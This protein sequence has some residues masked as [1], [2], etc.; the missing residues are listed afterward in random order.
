MARHALGYLTAVDPLLMAPQYPVFSEGTRIGRDAD[1]CDI[2]IASDFVSR[3]HCMVAADNGHIVLFDGAGGH[4]ASSNGTFVNGEPVTHHVLSE[5]DTISC[6]RPSPPHFVYTRTPRSQER[7]FL[8]ALQ[9]NYLIGRLGE[10]D[11][12]LLEDPTVSSR[13]ATLRARGGALSIHDAGSANGLYVNGERVGSAAIHPQDIVRIGSTE[14]TFELEA[15][16]LRVT[17]RER[18]NQV[19]MRAVDL[20]R[21][22]RGFTL[23]HGIDLDI[24][25]GAFVGVLGPSGAG[26]STLLNALNGFVPADSGEVLLNG[27]SLYRAYD[28]FRN[29]IGYVP[30]DDIIH[31]ELTVERS[32]L[33]TAQLRLPRDYSRPALAEQV[34]SVIETLGLT[35]VRHNFVSNLSGGQRKR[36]SIGCELLTR[37]SLMF[38]DEPTSGLDPSTEEKLMLHFRRMSEQGQTVVLTTHILYNLQLLDKVILLSRGRLVYY[39]PTDG[40]CPFFSTPGRTIERPIEVF[41]ILEPE[42]ADSSLRDERAEFY[43]EKYQREREQIAGS[44]GHGTTGRPI[45]IESNKGASAGMRLKKAVGSFLDLRQLGILVRRSFDLK[46]SFPMR[47]AVPMV[48]PILLALLT[49]TISISD[50]GA[51]QDERA[52]FEQSHAQDLAMM[53]Q[54]GLVTGAEYLALRFEGASNLPIPMSLPLLMVMTAVFL[55]TVTACLEISGERP[56]YLRERSVNLSIPIYVASKLPSLFLLTAVQCFLYVLISMVALGVSHVDILTLILITTAV[57][58]VS[59]TVGLLISSLDPTSGQNS[60]VLAVIAVLPQLIFSGAME[61]DFYGGMN[62]LTKGLASILPARWG[63]ELML[64]ALYEQPSWVRDMI[65]GTDNGDGMGFRFGGDVFMTNMTALAALGMG[66]FMLTC[67]SLKRYDRL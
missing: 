56:I 67:I 54:G 29:S 43:A 39:G 52:Q 36:V 33:Y 7:T 10:N 1:A 63:F 17:A 66:Y 14:L 13:H 46:L 58:W 48:T 23:L 20:R 6:G 47:L 31:R 51:L 3:H 18:R 42:T 65:T 24:E 37:P 15:E 41:D 44:N 11:L 27:A 4:K 60:V 12:P 8:L 19:S 21:E 32:L 22:S 5:G 62:A 28:M 30:Q 55:G 2:I 9:E 64:T 26:K 25:P 57:A 59:C 38:L 50:I 40:V 16:G 34:N 53:D 61:P 45:Q 49:A 35:H